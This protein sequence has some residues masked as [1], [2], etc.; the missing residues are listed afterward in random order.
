MKAGRSIY[1]LIL[2][3][4]RLGARTDIGEVRNDLLGVLSLTGTR[5]ATS[6]HRVRF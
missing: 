3:V 2:L 1:L 5:L 6:F 4:A